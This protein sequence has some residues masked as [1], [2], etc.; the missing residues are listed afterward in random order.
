MEWGDT[1]SFEKE[2]LKYRK[3]KSAVREKPFRLAIYPRM[4]R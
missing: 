3:F 1:R 4:A 2:K